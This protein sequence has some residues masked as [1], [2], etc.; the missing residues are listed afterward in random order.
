M[1]LLCTVRNMQL[2][3]SAFHSHLVY[4]WAPLPLSCKVGK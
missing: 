4:G 2:N 3:I 1:M